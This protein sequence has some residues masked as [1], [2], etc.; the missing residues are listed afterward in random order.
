MAYYLSC[1]LLLQVFTVLLKAGAD[2]SKTYKHGKSLVY[3]AS[4]KNAVNFVVLL[5]KLGADLDIPTTLWKQTPLFIAA[6]KG[7]VQVQYVSRSQSIHHCFT[8]VR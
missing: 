2:I 8:T 4:E 3:I 7:H 1:L 5:V 6:K